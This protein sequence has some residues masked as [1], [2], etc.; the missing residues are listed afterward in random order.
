VKILTLQEAASGLATWLQL[1]A[2]GERIL[3]RNGD[4]LLELRP[5]DDYG[6]A[7]LTNSASTPAPLPEFL[8]GAQ[9]HD[10]E[11]APRRQ[12]EPPLD[13]PPP[14]PFPRFVATQR[15]NPK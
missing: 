13:W 1:A 5:V 8:A 3:I 9:R 10:F 4:A 11:P 6:N 2:A 12:P 7:R 14:R 15:R